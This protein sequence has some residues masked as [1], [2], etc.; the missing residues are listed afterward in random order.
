MRLITLPVVMHTET[1]SSSNKRLKETQIDRLSELPDSL[2]I[3][4]LSLL[5]VKQSAITAVLT[6]RYRYLWRES[7]SLIF[8]ETTQLPARIRDFVAKVNR[9]L[10]FISGVNRNSFEAFEIQFYY[11][12]IYSSDVDVWF[13]FAVRNKVKRL[14]V[15]LL[16]ST[17]R[18]SYSL[19]QMMFHNSNLKR[20]SLRGCVLA[21]RKKIEWQSLTKLTIGDVELPEHVIGN[22]LSGCPVLHRLF[23]INCWGFDCLE[24]ES[25]RVHKLYVLN[26][27]NKPNLQ[28]SAPYVR[29]L[30]VWLNS[31]GRKLSL[32]KTSSL[33]EATIV[34]SGYDNAKELLEKIWHVKKVRIGGGFN[35]ILSSLAM[36]IGYRFPQSAQKWLSVKARTEKQS[37]HGIMGQ[38]QSS[39]KLEVLVV[40]GLCLEEEQPI[41]FPI[42]KGE[43]NCDLLH[44]KTITFRNFVDLN[45]EGDPMI[46]LARV[47]LNKA[48]ALEKMNIEG[49]GLSEPLNMKIAQ[50]LLSYPRSSVKAVI[51]LK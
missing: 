19:P 20:L 32:G 18:N 37:I 39:P 17:R 27:E 48:P 33:V 5:E 10:L 44:L 12:N 46:T 2:I 16:K 11:K 49:I 26:Q 40:E 41:V 36:Q 31:N 6:K 30:R 38:L 34:S 21:P 50:A 42:W 1:M 22:I 23:I 28:I 4:I 8:T 14:T 25:K 15:L 3:H 35:Q 7:P 9:T 51:F 45:L 29:V 13:D 24:V 43:L 47:L